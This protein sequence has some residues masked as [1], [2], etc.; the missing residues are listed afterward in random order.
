VDQQGGRD[1]EAV[2]HFVEHMAML[3]ADWGF[4]RM[5]ARVLMVMTAADEP[6]LTAGELAERLGVS[7]A[8]ISGAVRYLVQIGMAVREPVP[9]S[10]RDR[11]RLT[12]HTWYEATLTKLTIFRTV[13]DL[14]VEGAKALGGSASPSGARVTEMRDYFLFVEQELP[15]VLEK[16]EATKPHYPAD[17]HPADLPPP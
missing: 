1:E 5:A 8:A 10:R 3:F 11:Y 12:D 6:A 17:L 14:A 9:G 4:P 13:A 15:T 2:R 16:W 7:P